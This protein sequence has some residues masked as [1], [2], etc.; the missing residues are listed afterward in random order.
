[1][2]TSHRWSL[3]LTP[4]LVLALVA[5]S[6][7]D[8]PSKTEAAADDDPSVV[9]ADDPSSAAPSTSTAPPATVTSAPAPSSTA[10]DE[11]ADLAAGPTSTAADTTSSPTTTSAE[12]PDP[13]DT[14]TT[15][16][17]VAPTSGSPREGAGP[18]DAGLQPFI[19]Q[20]ARDLAGRLG[21]AVTEVRVDRAVLTT[22]PDGAIGCPDPK[23]V[24]TQVPVDGSAIELSAAGATWWYH[25]GGAISP[26]LCESP[27]RTPPT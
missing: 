16:S 12:T 5:A 6:C 4:V 19:D 13:A 9:A 17:G 2:P 11:A 3:S 14:T 18:I 15:T 10:T 20:A 23:M 24:Y 22:W 7:G 8:D 26:F 1:M 27:L 25:S 21:I